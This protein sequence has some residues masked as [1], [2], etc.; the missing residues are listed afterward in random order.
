MPRT[1]RL[2]LT[3]AAFA[4]ALLYPAAARA[5]TL[6]VYLTRGEQLAPVHRDVPHGAAVVSAT[7]NALLAGPT[8]DERRAGYGTAIPDGSSL[9]RARIDAK[10]RLAIV[11]FSG[12]FGSA[13]KLPRTDEEYREI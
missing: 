6:D 9:A 12:R 7:L 11:R 3:C 10:R 8:A 13:T 4:A 2:L 5:A 1:C